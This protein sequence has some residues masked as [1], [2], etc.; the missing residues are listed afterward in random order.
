MVM[1]LEEAMKNLVENIQASQEFIDMKQA[2][3][4]LEKNPRLKGQLEKFFKDN[5]EMGECRRQ[6]K[7]A[8]FTP[9]EMKSRHAKLLQIGE[10][11]TYFEANQNFHQMMLNMHGFIDEGVSK[12]LY[13]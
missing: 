10:I 6:G 11:A 4:V 9:D 5:A 12:A 8:N 7:K 13:E 1:Q 2:N 3:I